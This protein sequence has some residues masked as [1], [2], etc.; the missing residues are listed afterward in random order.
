MLM[1]RTLCLKVHRE[2]D[3]S[4]KKKHVHSKKIYL[5][6][7]KIEVYENSVRNTQKSQYR[8]TCFFSKQGSLN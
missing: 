8:S 3:P 1:L 2:I 7:Q 4:N 6:K 5:S